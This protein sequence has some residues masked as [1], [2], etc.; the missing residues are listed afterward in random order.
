MSD[1]RV[2]EMVTPAPKPD[3]LP[4]RLIALAEQAAH[5]RQALLSQHIPD[6]LADQLVRDW[7]ADRLTHLYNGMF[8]YAW[9][10]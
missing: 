5:Y 4:D 9:E 8:T 3:P 10:R 1:I 7:H 2:R 6:A